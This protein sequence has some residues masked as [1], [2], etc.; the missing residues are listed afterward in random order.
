MTPPPRFV[1]SKP[2]R[3]KKE[4]RKPAT[5]YLNTEYLGFL[6]DQKQPDAEQNPLMKKE[7]RQAI[8]YGFD[9][10]KMLR[11]LRSGIGIP[12][13]VGSAGCSEGCSVGDSSLTLEAAKAG[14]TVMAK[15][16]TSAIAMA[17]ILKFFIFIV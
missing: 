15:T 12:G 11:H 7:I 6:V 4:N 16:I 2:R 5:P 1:R 10:E 8:N 14:T 9:R 3:R 17:R 13:A